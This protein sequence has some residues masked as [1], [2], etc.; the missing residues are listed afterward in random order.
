MKK[1][2]AGLLATM[3]V[4]AQ[5][6][7]L[8]TASVGSHV[9]Q[10][11]PSGYVDGVGFGE[12]GLN[13]DSDN[14]MMINLGFEH[15]L[16]FLPNIKVASTNLSLEGGSNNTFTF[17]DESFSGD[18]HAEI[19]LSH[20]DLTLYWGLPI[21]LPYIDINF[22]L[23]A[24]NFDGGATVMGK[25]TGGGTETQTL[26]FNQVMPMGYAGVKLGEFFGVYARAD[27]NYIGYDN[28]T[29]TDM[30]ALVGYNLPIPIVDV[31]IEGGYRQLG[32]ETDID[33]FVSDIDI[34]GPF[35]GLELSIGF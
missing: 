29:L 31:K 35:A 21:P 30:Q 5:A 18:A 1:L 20:M 34:S 16:P 10:A 12:G 15:P 2:T 22:G 14:G 28:N 3:A 8:F 27:M 7:I 4:S 17:G 11:D 6:D 24:R 32:V 9:W 25:V 13:I 33:D 23:T 26:E 19:D